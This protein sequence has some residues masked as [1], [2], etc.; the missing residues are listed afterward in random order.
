[1]P[2]TT[3]VGSVKYVRVDLPAWHP[4]AQDKG[5]PGAS[6]VLWLEPEAAEAF[7]SR[8]LEMELERTCVC[9]AWSDPQSCP[10]CKERS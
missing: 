3:Y 6:P 9:D 4:L 8:L 7:Q 1:M 10:V 2:E 5:F